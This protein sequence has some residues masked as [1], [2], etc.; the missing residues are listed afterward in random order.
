MDAEQ[1]ATT[2]LLLD[3]GERY[4][5]ALL[6]KQVAGTCRLVSRAHVD[7]THK[8]PTNNAS[9]GVFEALEKLE[10]MSSQTILSNDKELILHTRQPGRGVD[11]FLTSISMGGLLRTVIVAPTIDDPAVESAVHLLQRFPS[12]LEKL[13]TGSNSQNLVAEVQWMAE[14][15]PDFVFLVGSDSRGSAM[16]NQMLKA[17]QPVG[18]GIRQFSDTSRPEVIYAASG[19]WVEKVQEQLNIGSHLK[20]APNLR[21]DARHEHVKPARTLIEDLLRRTYLAKI[22]GLPEVMRWS[23]EMPFARNEGLAVFARYQAALVNGPVLIL[24]LDVNGLTLVYAK[25]KFTDLIV[26]PDLGLGE[27]LAQLESKLDIQVLSQWLTGYD[28]SAHAAE[29]LRIHLVNRS[30]FQDTVPQT[31]RD[32]DLD[33]VMLQGLIMQAVEDASSA[34]GLEQ[35]QPL[36]LNRLFVRGDLLSLTGNHERLVLSL[37]NA[38]QIQ[39][40]CE[41]F[42]DTHNAMALLGEL[43]EHHPDAAVDVIESD[44]FQYL[45]WLVGLSGR[46]RKGQNALDVEL[47]KTNNDAATTK[48]SIEW[49]NL[50]S[51]EL[52][53]GTAYDAKLSHQRRGFS[54]GAANVSKLEGIEGLMARV[55]VDS[56]GRPIVLPDDKMDEWQSISTK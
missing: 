56:R 47:S 15:R 25:P 4:T 45:G 6:I 36:S 5:T 14:T 54:L 3:I 28:D 7:S 41:C 39:G 53:N 17:V 33:L 40:E 29:T 51:I 21:P 43:L 26:R 34:W 52:S 2:F 23:G 19:H 55:W 46:G 27:N 9:K 20:I 37:F 16:Q 11:K 18:A 30:I 32:L 1:T 24:D 13:Y 10:K 48:E 50:T 31:K 38:L 44:A 8:A 35:D 22:P 12:K 49:G 42:T